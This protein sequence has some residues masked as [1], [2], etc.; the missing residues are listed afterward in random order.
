MTINSNTT[1]SGFFNMPAMKDVVTIDIETIGSIFKRMLMA[2]PIAVPENII[3]KKCP[4]L[5]PVSMQTFVRTIFI[6]LVK[7]KTI[8][9]NC[10]PVPNKRYICSS[11][12]NI[13]SG[14]KVPII[15]SNNPP[16]IPFMINLF[17][18]P[19]NIALTIL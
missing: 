8:N 13:A 14:K 11:P 18:R 6:M 1:A 12:E 4:P 10:A 3:G 5:S 16:M 7:I 15:P 17:S 2:Y 9:P 19:L